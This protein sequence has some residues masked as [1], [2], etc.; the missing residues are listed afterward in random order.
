MSLRLERACW[1]IQRE[2]FSVARMGSSS[3]RVMGGE[4]SKKGSSLW[5]RSLEYHSEEVRFW[6]G[7]NRAKY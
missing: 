5:I 1:T 3:R 2:T 6:S 7:D 4:P